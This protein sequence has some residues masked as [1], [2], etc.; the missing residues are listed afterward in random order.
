MEINEIE[1]EEIMNK[2]P[3]G[4]EIPSRK[5]IRGEQE[6]NRMIAKEA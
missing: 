6:D 3:C 4:G 1:E 2:I 5:N